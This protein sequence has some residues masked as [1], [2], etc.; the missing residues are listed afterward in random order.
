MELIIATDG[1][2]KCT[3]F[4]VLLEGLYHSVTFLTEYAKL[5]LSPGFYLFIVFDEDLHHNVLELEIHDGSN[6]L[7]LWPH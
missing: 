5:N 7:L 6:S 2:R 1:C 3:M 4:T